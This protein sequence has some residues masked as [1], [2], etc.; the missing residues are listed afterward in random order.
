MPGSRFPLAHFVHLCNGHEV[1]SLKAQVAMKRAG[2]CK[3]RNEVG[4]W[5]NARDASVVASTSCLPGHA[6][7]TEETVRVTGCAQ[8]CSVSSSLHRM[9][10]S[11][12]SA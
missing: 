7:R 4:L 3:E 11:Q 10:M 9:R 6:D 1:L 5:V 2:I 12:K 8:L